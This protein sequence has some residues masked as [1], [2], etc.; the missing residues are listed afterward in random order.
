MMHTACSSSHG[1]GVSTRPLLWPSGVAAF[2]YGLLVWCCLVWWPSGVVAFCYGLLLPLKTIPEGC[3]QSEGH[4]TRRASQKITTEGH[5]PQ[6]QTPPGSR[7]PPPQS[8]PPPGADPPKDLL[9]GMLGYHLQCM[10]G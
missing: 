10:L 8:S 1:G 5:T 6:E 7:H 4:Q 9:Q 2:C 3:L